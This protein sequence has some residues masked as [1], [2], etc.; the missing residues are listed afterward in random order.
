MVFIYKWFLER[1]HKQVIY[2]KKPIIIYHTMLG[3]HPLTDLFERQI[4]HQLESHHHH[5]GHPEKQDVMPRLQE[6]AGVE[7]LQLT[8]LV[9]TAT[10]IQPV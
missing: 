5:P 2:C 1:I 3:H 6:R 7:T 9:T 10:K 4:S 8:C